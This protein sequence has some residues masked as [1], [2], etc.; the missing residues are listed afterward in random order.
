LQPM[1]I[2]L[3]ELLPEVPPTP[4]LIEAIVAGFQDALGIE[5][6]RESRSD[7]RRSRP[8]LVC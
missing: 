7:T 8:E 6:V 2:S 3:S 4:V 1:S 5:F